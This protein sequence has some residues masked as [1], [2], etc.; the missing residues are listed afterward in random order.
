MKKKYFYYVTIPE[1]YVHTITRTGINA[2]DESKIIL[3]GDKDSAHANATR[4]LN[5]LSYGILKIDP[6]GINTE[7]IPDDVEGQ[8][9]IKQQSISSE[10]IHVVQFCTI[11]G[12]KKKG[13]H[14]P[15]N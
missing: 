14:H 11:I 7:I 3:F 10:H 2:N 8:F 4:L 12:K 5:N 1:T 13:K 15:Y 9:Y 6:K